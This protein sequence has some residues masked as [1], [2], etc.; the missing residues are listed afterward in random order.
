MNEPSK[1]HKE[2][3]N[4]ILDGIEPSSNAKKAVFN[5][6]RDLTDRGRIGDE[7][8]QIDGEIQDE[9][10]EKWMECIVSANQN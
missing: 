7:F 6:I 4:Y 10:I 8:C 3:Y 5:I 1:Y 2:Y 9:I